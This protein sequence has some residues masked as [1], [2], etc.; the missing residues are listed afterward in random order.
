LSIALAV[1][2][3]LPLAEGPQQLDTLPGQVLFERLGR[4][5]LI[6]DH[7]DAGVLGTSAASLRICRDPRVS[8]S[9]VDD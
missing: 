3:L 8:A 2:D 7:Q 9:P 1:A 6:D 5:T 4:E